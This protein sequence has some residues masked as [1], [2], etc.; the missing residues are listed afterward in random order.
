MR[1]AACA[2]GAGWLQDDRIEDRSDFTYR[3]QLKVE[4]AIDYSELQAAI[5]AASE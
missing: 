3:K 2:G 4:D 5:Q 1:L